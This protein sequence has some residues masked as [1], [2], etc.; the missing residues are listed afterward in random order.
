VGLSDR[1]IEITVGYVSQRKQFGVPIGSFQAIKHHLADATLAVE[2]AKPVVWRAAASITNEDPA[3]S[4]HASMAKAAASDAAQLASDV[5]LQC[6]GAIG[7]TVE[8]DL[9]LS[10]KRAW[11]LIRRAGDA[12]F[13]RRR[14]AAALLD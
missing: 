1:M 14:V 10:M 6:H 8:Y 4:V 2:F 13:H 11:A 12:R 9:H 7:Y 3:A 5:A